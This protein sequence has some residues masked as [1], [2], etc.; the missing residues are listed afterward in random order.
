MVRGVTPNFSATAWVVITEEAAFS[1]QLLQQTLLTC[2]VLRLEESNLSLC[3]AGH[4]GALIV[5]ADGELQRVENDGMLPGLIPDIEYADTHINLR[6]GE[7]LAIFTDGLY[8]SLTPPLE[9]DA[10]KALITQ[11]LIDTKD[12][13]IQEASKSVFDCFDHYVMQLPT[14]DA[15]LLLIEPNV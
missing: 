11:Q 2:C 3:S 5:T 8:E 1:D 6:K 13:T 4:P 10:A 7:R 14:D 9:S 12:Q 15:T